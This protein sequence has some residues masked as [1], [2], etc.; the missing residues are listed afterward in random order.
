MKRAL[1]AVATVAL[2]L[3]VTAGPAGADP[4]RPTNYRSTV[5]K[6]SPPAAG[7]TLKVAGG[8]GFL[9]LDVETGHT[10]VVS[11]YRDEPYLRVKPD[12]NV[13][14]NTNSPATY[15]NRDRYARSTVPAPLNGNGDLPAPAWRKIG[16]GGHAVWHDHRIHFMGQDPGVVAGLTDGRPVDWTVNL[17]VDG[18]PTVVSGSYRLLAAPSPLPWLAL[19]VVVGLAL[20]WLGKS[21]PVL[22]AAVATTLAGAM[23]LFVGWEQNAAIPAGAGATQ[24]TVILPG[25]CL[26]GG[27]V[28][29]LKRQTPV[30]VI[31]ALA[32]VAAAGGWF[33]TRS[34]VWW[35]AELPTEI[36]PGID[37][38][39]SAL[40]VGLVVGAAV[41]LI[42][43][44]A[45]AKQTA[46][47]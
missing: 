32:G 18:E 4:A 27:V 28:A 22:L 7:V 6:V 45:L 39:L 1:V 44:G 25:L 46:N 9:D 8:D 12:G 17:T 19:A 31:A 40:V 36:S 24:L 10:V 21:T 5:T 43:S 20:A 14:E 34:S 33:L 29:I 2:L 47:T 35:K 13:E 41:L 42:R 15:L 30:G 37:R 16:S 38:G 23:A 3:L 11:G 26:L